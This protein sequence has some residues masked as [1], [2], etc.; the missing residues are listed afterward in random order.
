MSHGGQKVSLCGQPRCSLLA[1]SCAGVCLSHTTHLTPHPRSVPPQL[2][3]KTCEYCRVEISL[4]LLKS[5]TA[6]NIILIYKSVYKS[7]IFLFV[8]HSQSLAGRASSLVRKSGIERSL[9]VLWAALASAW[10]SLP[11]PSSLNLLLCQPGKCLQTPSLAL[12]LYPSLLVWFYLK[13]ELNI[14]L[15]SIPS[16]SQSGV[17]A[18]S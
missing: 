16:H 7:N 15:L 5:R 14:P 1:V 11:T 17:K 13:L 18:H 3:N 2:W 12:N 4:L 6:G 10:G 9:Q 8:F